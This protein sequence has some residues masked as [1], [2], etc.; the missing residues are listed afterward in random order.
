MEPRCG[1]S[2]I[3]LTHPPLR[4]VDALTRPDTIRLIDGRP[5]GGPDAPVSHAAAEMGFG[6]APERIARP[7]GV[8]SSP[9]DPPA[10]T[11]ASSIC[12]APGHRAGRAA[13]GR[14]RWRRRSCAF[15]RREGW[16]WGHCLLRGRCRLGFRRSLLGRSR[17]ISLGLLCRRR[18]R[19]FE[20]FLYGRARNF[21]LRGCSGRRCGLRCRRLRLNGVLR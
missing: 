6:D 1:G 9:C 12:L 11:L 8:P 10:C 13:R 2:P 16:R 7:R 14:D 19:G 4:N 3:A 21:T 18:S 5:V 17:G 20:R 15:R